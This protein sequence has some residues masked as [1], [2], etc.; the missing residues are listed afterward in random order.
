MYEDNGARRQTTLTPSPITDKYLG[1]N[2]PN[3]RGLILPNG[4][5]YK[6]Q[7]GAKQTVVDIYLFDYYPDLFNVPLMRTK[8]NME[9]GEEWSPEPGDLVAVTFLGGDF[10]DPLVM[11]CLAPA[12][13]SIDATTEE[14][15]RSHRKRNGTWERV[16]KDGTRR[17]HVAMSELM[18]VTQDLLVSIINGI[19]KIISKGK[20]T[21]QSE[22]TVQIDGIGNE[23]VKGIVQG[24]SICAYTGKPHPHISAS[25]TG[26]K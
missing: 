21:L 8:I 14:A 18:E 2:I 25:V 16:E 4:V 6:D 5:R 9:N 17:V 20:I 22:G 11:G 15:P 19:T 23:E 1:G 12:G 13:N 24:D 7:T 10:G 3:L 26:S